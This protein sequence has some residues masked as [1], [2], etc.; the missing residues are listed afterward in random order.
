MTK[1]LSKMLDTTENQWKIYELTKPGV[2][3]QY[4]YE[5]IK[6]GQAVA[7]CKNCE[8][9][10][11]PIDI[12]LS[13]DEKWDYVILQEAPVR[14]LIPEKRIHSFEKYSIKL[15]SLIKKAGG[16]TILFLPYRISIKYP[17]K[18]C[19]LANPDEKC[20]DEICCSDTL[21][22]SKDEMKIY[23]TTAQK[24]QNSYGFVIVPVGLAFEEAMRINPKI[25]LYEDNYS[26]PSKY[27]SFLM[28]SIYFQVLTQRKLNFISKE[29]DLDYENLNSLITISYLYLN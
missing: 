4:H 25:N 22:T 14:I 5:S 10:E 12:N 28:A 1:T 17:Q 3:L 26:H 7:V 20:P 11:E 8:N 13:S 23:T 15:D 6:N 29:D 27:G 21:K 24:L 9:K 18:Y 2:W 19:H 16:R